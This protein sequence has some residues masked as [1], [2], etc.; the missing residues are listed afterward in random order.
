MVCVSICIYDYISISIY[1]LSI[2]WCYKPNYNWG[3]PGMYWIELIF[4]KIWQIFQI[5]KHEFVY[6]FDSWNMQIIERQDIQMIGVA[7]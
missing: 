1:R 7:C 3:A 4:G 6:S 2:S 5:S